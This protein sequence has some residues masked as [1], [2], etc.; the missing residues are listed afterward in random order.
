MTRKIFIAVLG[1]GFY[2]QC[3]Y[4]SGTFKSSETRFIQQAT[5][6]LIKAKEWKP[7]DEVFILLTAKARTFNWDLPSNERYSPNSKKN[8][9]YKGL[10][11]ILMEM[12]LPLRVSTGDIPNGN[13]EKEIWSI[14]N[15]MYHE[16]Q[17]GDEV[18]LDLTHSFR[19]LPMLLLVL[20][21][22]A[23]FLKKIKVMRISY[24]NYE[25]RDGE[26]NTAPIIDLLPLS[27]LQDW[28]FAAASYI[29]DGSADKLSALGSDLLQPMLRDEKQRT[30]NV[31]DLKRLIK[32][33]QSVT[34]EHRTCRG[35]DLLNG[36]SI[37]LLKEKLAGADNGLIEPFGPIIDIIKESLNLYSET[38][39]AYNI[40]LAARWSLNHGLYQSAA[41]LLQEGVTTY[42]CLRHH[43]QVDDEDMRN[44]IHSSFSIKA[45][46]TQ[47]Q[48]WRC[49]DEDRKEVCQSTIET[50]LQDELFGNRPF[51]DNFMSLSELRNDIN[52][53]GMRSKKKPLAPDTIKKRI[54]DSISFFDGIFQN[55]TPA[56]EQEKRPK[57][58]INLSNHPLKM[59][60]EKQ[61]EAAAVY[62]EVKDLP[63][64]AIDPA[65]D[66]AYIELMAQEYCEKIEEMTRTH[67]VTVHLMGEMTFTFALLN[68]LQNL[69]ITCVAST[70][71]R[72]VNEKGEKADF[73]FEKFRPYDESK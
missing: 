1:T 30:T 36:T 62:G 20:C 3:Q 28:T 54:Q 67:T 31:M 47:R 21:N 48:D 68:R 72:V 69:G 26:S 11:Q 15:T 64:P 53:S 29:E 38:K 52:H 45:N 41:T 13:N 60:S 50:M 24:G 39:N 23:K 46:G 49:S 33:M 6:E 43:I 58:F 32:Y 18:Y 8:E 16:L 34:D 61:L 71:R 37:K 19:F 4:C 14:F 63:F 22:Y 10:H 73:E 35:M 51:I 55:A 27:A 5:L 65:G 66:T 40:L 70:T 42:L 56:I 12:G 2:E 9:P 25:A 57:L 59:W 7:Q 17:E 44:Y